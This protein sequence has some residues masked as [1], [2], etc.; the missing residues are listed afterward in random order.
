[1]NTREQKLQ[2]FDRLLTIMD[3][4]REQCPWDKKQTMQTLRH[5]T[6]EETYELGDAILENDLEE[7]K[8]ELGDVLLHIVFYSKIG[9]ETGDFDIADV[10]NNI[11]EK[12]INRHPHIYGDVKVTSEEDVKRNWEN[13]KLKEGKGKTSVLEGVPKG[14]PAL[15]KASRIQDKV[16]G[17]GFDWEKPEQVWEKVQEELG[18]L[19]A[20][21]KINDQDKMES[22][23]GD[24]MFA[25]V[26]YAR[27]LNISPENALERTNKK[28]I[29]RFQY[30]EGKAKE[31]GK[32]LKEM[33]LAEMDVFWEEAKQAQ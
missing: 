14:L 5:L 26:N 27:F 23:F 3:E 16:A 10:C 8:K 7:V 33:T 9:S 24:V 19:Q 18:E 1:M 31:L 15:V 17:V 2:A 30:L 22:E 12:L 4:L 29:G 25:M 28:F 20:E 13:I 6:I 11:C 32:E 21:V